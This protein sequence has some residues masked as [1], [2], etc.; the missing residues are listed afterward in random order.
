MKMHIRRVFNVDVIEDLFNIEI[1]EG[2]LSLHDNNA[3]IGMNMI[4]E[5]TGQEYDHF[6]KVDDYFDAIKDYLKKV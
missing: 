3:T 2:G 1:G 5:E 4:D 6:I